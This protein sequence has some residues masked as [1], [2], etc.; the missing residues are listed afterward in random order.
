VKLGGQQD[1]VAFVFRIVLV[2]FANGSACMEVFKGLGGII[3]HNFKRN[4]G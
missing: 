3:T 2:L 4:M 1:S